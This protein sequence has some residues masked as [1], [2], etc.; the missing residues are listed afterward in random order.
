MELSNFINSNYLCVVLFTSNDF[1]KINN[2]IKNINEIKNKLMVINLD[3]NN[4][5]LNDI[6]ITSIPLVHIYKNKKLIEDIF[7][8]YVNICNIIKLHF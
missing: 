3:D 7:G 2:N 8:N 1:E 5:D 6:F 4:I